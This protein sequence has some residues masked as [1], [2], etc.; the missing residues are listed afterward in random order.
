MFVVRLIDGGC[1]IGLWASAEVISV[2][3]AYETDTRQTSAWE[4]RNSEMVTMSAV[5]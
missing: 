5:A 2:L 1:T 4:M 3:L